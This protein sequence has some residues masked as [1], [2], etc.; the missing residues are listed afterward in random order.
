[1][2]NA[3]EVYLIYIMVG[4][5]NGGVRVFDL[6]KIGETHDHGL[7]KNTERVTLG[8]GPMVTRSCHA[9]GRTSAE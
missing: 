4:H 5:F 1:M 7:G 6:S 9:L 2:V 8:F 3:S